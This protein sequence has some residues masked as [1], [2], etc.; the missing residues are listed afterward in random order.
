[1]K[2]NWEFI[3][4]KRN[5]TMK[6]RLYFQIGLEDNEGGFGNAMEFVSW[7]QRLFSNKISVECCVPGPGRP[8]WLF[9]EVLYGNGSFE[10]RSTRQSMTFLGGRAGLQQEHSQDHRTLGQGWRHW[11]Q[12]RQNIRHGFIARSNLRH[13]LWPCRN[14]CKR[15]TEWGRTTATT[16]NWICEI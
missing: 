6:Y 11:S 4:K 14:N 13:L 12:R 10:D 1:M 15:M 8:C 7:T 2:V 16:V 9:M 3:K 5:V